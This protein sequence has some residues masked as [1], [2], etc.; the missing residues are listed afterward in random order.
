MDTS[1]QHSEIMH[2]LGVL[3]GKVDGIIT[4]QDF[5]NGRVGKLEGKVELIEK[6]QARADGRLTA[7]GW[8]FGGGISVIGLILVAIQVYFSVHK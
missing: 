5:A 4:R 2:K 7:Y 6:Q 1:I 3:E 8:I